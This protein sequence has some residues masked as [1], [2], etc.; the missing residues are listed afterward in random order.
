MLVRLRSGGIALWLGVATAL[1]GGTALAA[2]G[3][4][5]S[6]NF[7]TPSGVPNYF[8]NEAGPMIGGGAESRRGELYSGQAPRAAVPAASVPVPAASVAAAPAP[9]GRTHIAMAVPRGRAVVHGRRAAPVHHVAL[10]GR[11]PSRGG[12]AQIAHTS[13]RTTHAAGKVRVTTTHRHARG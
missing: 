3:G 8:S 7:D 10:Y 9:Q 11:A 6:K 13:G 1:I 4:N 5:G 12:H 2:G